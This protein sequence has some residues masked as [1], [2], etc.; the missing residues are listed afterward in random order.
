LELVLADHI[1]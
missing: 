1:L